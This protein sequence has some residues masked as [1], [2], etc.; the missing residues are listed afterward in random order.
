MKLTEMGSVASTKETLTKSTAQAS[1]GLTSEILT[2]LT[3]RDSGGSASEILTKLTDRDS[4]VLQNVP[5][6]TLMKLIGQVL[7][8]FPGHTKVTEVS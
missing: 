5:K 3:V 2:K 8:D 4:A 7:V 6:R 1:G